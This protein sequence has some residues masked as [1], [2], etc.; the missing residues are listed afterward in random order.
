MPFE[1]FR[2]PESARPDDV[3]KR[4]RA[5]DGFQVST[6]GSNFGVVKVSMLDLGD[7]ALRDSDSLGKLLLSQTDIFT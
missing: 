1:R 5:T 2:Q 4:E 7:L 6:D 3:L